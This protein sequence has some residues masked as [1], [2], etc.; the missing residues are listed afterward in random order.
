MP[1]PTVAIGRV[2]CCS[3]SQFTSLIWKG[4]LHPS[5]IWNTETVFYRT[6]AA[7][8]LH[9][10]KT[11]VATPVI[12]YRT[13]ISSLQIKNKAYPLHG[14]KSSGA[15]QKE[16]IAMRCNWLRISATRL[17]GLWRGSS[18]FFLG[19]LLHQIT[20]Q[21][22]GRPKISMESNHTAPES[23]HTPKVV[24]LPICRNVSGIIA[25]NC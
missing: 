24:F 5:N 7:L 3:S 22:Q 16:E 12:L 17:A 10:C 8:S 9:I 4:L 23:E 13:I 15:G 25:E 2:C 6:M 14:S 20:W 21:Y 18:H 11:K 19:L 1:S